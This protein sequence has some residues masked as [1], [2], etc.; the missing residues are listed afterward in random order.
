MIIDISES[1]SD[2]QEAL[3]KTFGLS[4]EQMDSAE[5]KMTI[6]NLVRIYV[7]HDYL[8]WLTNKPIEGAC[9]AARMASVF[10]RYAF[11]DAYVICKEISETL[12]RIDGF[13][14]E[15]DVP[16]ELMAK[17]FTFDDFVEMAFCEDSTL[18]SAL[19]DDKFSRET[20][21]QIEKATGDHAATR[22]LKILPVITLSSA[23]RSCF[24]TAS[25]YNSMIRSIVISD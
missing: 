14:D 18:T 21:Y 5:G 19:T 16:E 15:D 11:A 6:V 3:S 9:M 2:V 23:V 17:Q 24:K 4:E 25:E 10:H 20:V 22:Y 7:Q 12:A 13:N 8:S 1:I